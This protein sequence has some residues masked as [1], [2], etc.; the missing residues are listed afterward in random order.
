MSR[1]GLVAICS[2]ALVLCAAC[3][4]HSAAEAQTVGAPAAQLSSEAPQ[5]KQV[6]EA[7]VGI[8]ERLASS[9]VRV[10]IREASTDDEAKSNP[11]EGTPLERFF[12][13][14]GEPP[15]ASPEPRIGMGS[16]VVIDDQGHI[17][18]NR[19]VVAHARDLRVTFVD[20]KEMQ[21]KVVGTD[22]K[23]DLAVIQVPGASA[24]PAQFGSSERMQVGQ[25]V[26]AIGNPFGLDHSVTVGVLSA[27]GRYGL[28]PGTLEDFLQTD[29]SINPGNSGGPL[30]NLD[31]EV[32]GINT[33]I[34]GIG[35]GVGFAVSEAIARPIAK[36]LIEHGKVSRPY[37]G[38]AM[39][40]LTPSLR[41]A[42]GEKAP[43]KGALVAH[44]ENGSPAE[45]AGIRAGDIVIR[46]AGKAT[47]DSREVQQAVLAHEIGEKLEVTLWRDGKEL[48]FA[49]RTTESPASSDET[50]QPA[51]GEPSHTKQGL[52]LQPLTPDLAERLGVDRNTQGVIIT[53]V[54]P[55]S[56]A[57]DAGL[58]PGDVVISI[59]K[60]P[61]TRPRS[62]TQLLS[63]RRSGGHLLRIE[64]G[65]STMFVV[66]ESRS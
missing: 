21:A 45:K 56:A 22:A 18:T 36:Q 58:R 40:P 63:Q 54:R 55:D 38:I 41:Q 10:T 9:V 5:P 4:A 51:K 65:D 29:A 46:V 64:R 14:F 13:E 23:T 7:F 42:I 34:A 20:G 61:A 37:V 43:E 2:C 6:S 52:T 25:W 49:V 16:G 19:H 17:L 39:Q 3:E 26:M 15:D 8:A 50:E 48:S 66:I 33:M 62:A 11:F 59:D 24:R 28:A 32:I 30:V 35:T 53:A 57:A 12:R 60:Q 1:T 31:G 27:K 47:A 44:V